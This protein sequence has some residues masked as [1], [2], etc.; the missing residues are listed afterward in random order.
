MVPGYHADGD[1]SYS[2]NVSLEQS[3]SGPVKAP[4][5][6]PIDAGFDEIECALLN[7]MLR[8]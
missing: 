4:L 8:L 5:H 1:F 2:L 6:R 7:S 3:R